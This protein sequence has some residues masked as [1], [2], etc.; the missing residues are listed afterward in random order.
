M[1]TQENIFKGKGIFSIIRN[2]RRGRSPGLPQFEGD[3]GIKWAGPET[4]PYFLRR[5]G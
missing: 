1:E 5:Y 2:K 4:S 3:I